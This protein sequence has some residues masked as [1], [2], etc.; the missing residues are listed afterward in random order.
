MTERRYNEDEVA[1]ILRKAVDAGADDRATATGKGMSLSELKEIGIEVGID[2]ARIEDAARTLERRD[3]RP[4]TGS[5]LGLPTTAQL[6]RVVPVRLVPEDLPQPLGRYT[7]RMRPPRHCRGGSRGH[8]MESPK[9][10]GRPLRFHSV[11]GRPGADS[12]PRKLPRPDDG[13][14]AWRWARS[15]HGG[16]GTRGFAGRSRSIGHPAD[17]ARRRR[18]RDDRTLAIPV[19]ARGTLGAPS[20]GR[21]RA[22]GAGVGTCRP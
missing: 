3:D 21:T 14:D 7:Q 2:A 18:T 22:A 6:D 12:C 1:L 10:H 8:R 15:R 17:C 11:R 16:R 13:D 9:R 20:A 19:R 5:V 4:I